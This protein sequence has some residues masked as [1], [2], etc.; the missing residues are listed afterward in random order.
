MN[1]CC[2]NGSIGVLSNF[3]PL[4]SGCVHDGADISMILKALESSGLML[5]G[6]LSTTTEIFQDKQQWDYPN[7]WAPLQ[8]VIIEG[9]ESAATT[10]SQALARKLASIWV[11]TNYVCPP[12]PLQ[13]GS[14]L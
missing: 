13:L 9:L 6:G 8:H 10:E 12:S 4:W 1:V 7:A 14:L 5:D 3:I 11:A 2:S